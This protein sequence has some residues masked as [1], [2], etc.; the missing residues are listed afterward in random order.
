MPGDHAG[1]GAAVGAAKA[2]QL[3][4][5]MPSSFHKMR[6]SD[7]LA[8]DLLGERGDGG[9][10]GGGAPRRA[11]RVVSPVG[12]VWDVE[13][14][15]DDDGD[16]GGAFLGR[17]WAEFAAAHGLGMGWFVVVRHEGGGVLTVKLF[18]TTCCLWDFGA[19][20]AVVTTRSG[21]ARDASHKPQ[22]LRVLLPGFMEKMRIPAKF[23]QHYIAEEHLNIHMASIL[24]PLGKFWRIELEKDELG[25]FFKGGWLQFLSFHGISPGDVV[26]LR[27]EGN[28]VFKIKVF[29]INGC[30]KDLKTKDDI[31]IQQSARNQHETPSFST[32]KCNKNSRFGEDCKNQLQ[33]IPCSIKGSRKK[34]RETK[35]PKKSKSIYEIGPPSWIKKEI[36]NYMLEN[37]NISLPG[38][39]CKSIGLVEET[40]ITLM[41]NSS[42]GRSSSSS[43]RSWEVACSVNKNGYG[44]CNLLPSGWKRFCQA[45][46]LLVGDVCTFSVVEATLWHV[47]IDRVERS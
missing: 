43:S 24:S 3:K 20:P 22:F 38:I 6:I 4:V 25:M 28:L 2:M 17:G 13:V 12:K 11:A 44:C 14:G 39:F 33:E 31:T 1:A 23:V 34:G 19:R 9:G 41:I 16:G 46:G 18:D 30:K 36:S 32:R 8:A 5:L 45:N 15:R 27:H 7:E 10:G 29:G 21:R 26:L 35:R 47:A 37:G 42:R 40:T